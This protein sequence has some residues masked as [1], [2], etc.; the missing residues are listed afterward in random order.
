MPPLNT[1][2]ILGNVVF[3]GA[4]KKLPVDWKAPSGDPGGK[5]YGDAIKPS[6][7]VAAPQLIPPWFMP[8]EPNKYFVDACDKVGQDFKDLHDAM[9][10]AVVFSHN[11]WKLQAKFQ[12]LQIMAL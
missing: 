7:K 1:I 3:L 11:M 10:D 9:I 2:N 4:G 8:A 5:Q 6:E 12:N